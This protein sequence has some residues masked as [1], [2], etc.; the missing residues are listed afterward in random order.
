MFG[1]AILLYVFFVSAAGFVGAPAVLGLQPQDNRGFAAFE[2]HT[3]GFG[4]RMLVRMGYTQGK[5]LGAEEQGIRT[6]LQHSR[7]TGRLGLGAVPD[8][9]SS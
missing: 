9:P 7:Q 3:T 2:R 8:I 4:S 5:G 1:I 6:P